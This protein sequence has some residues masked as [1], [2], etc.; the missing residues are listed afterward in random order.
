M[1][2]AL[3]AKI[4]ERRMNL[5]CHSMRCYALGYGVETWLKG[6]SP[7]QPL[8]DEGILAAGDEIA[9]T[10]TE[11]SGK[12]LSNLRRLGREITVYYNWC[13]IAMHLSR[14]VNWLFHLGCDGPPNKAD[15]KT[16][17]AKIYEFVDCDGLTDCIGHGADRTHQYYRQSPTVRADIT[18]SLA[19]RIPVRPKF[20]PVGNFYSFV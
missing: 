16:F 15:I 2:Y 17:P 3:R 9:T 7:A 10:F 1:L 18:A 4:G 20:D 8:F 19:A 6:Q 11:K 5:L 13:D 14:L 12:R